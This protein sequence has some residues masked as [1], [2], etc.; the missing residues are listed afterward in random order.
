MIL[1]NSAYP[2]L[3]QLIKDVLM[4]LENQKH[5]YCQNSLE[6][7]TTTIIL[8]GSSKEPVGSFLLQLPGSCESNVPVKR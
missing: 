2:N 3:S 7:N 5:V 4:Y 6:I 8:S 1:L